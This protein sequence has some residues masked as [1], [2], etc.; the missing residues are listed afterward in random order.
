M[1]LLTCTMCAVLWFVYL[2]TIHSFP[3]RIAENNLPTTVI[4]LPID[5]S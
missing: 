5:N 4:A 3:I 1:L 2:F